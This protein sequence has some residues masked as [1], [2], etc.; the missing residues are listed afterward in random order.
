MF[1]PDHSSRPFV[2]PHGGRFALGSGKSYAVAGVRQ[3]PGVPYSPAA[4][5]PLVRGSG[6]PS[7]PFG[8]TSIEFA[9]VWPIGSTT[10]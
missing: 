3:I 6:A 10:V 4:S 7:N 1:P 2:R 5:E 8:V 9:E